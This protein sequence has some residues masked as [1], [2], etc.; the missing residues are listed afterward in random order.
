MRSATFY[1]KPSS[2]D[3][4]RPRT[5]EEAKTLLQGVVK[6]ELTDEEIKPI[7]DI[8]TRQLPESLYEIV[9]RI[10]VNES[11]YDDFAKNLLSDRGFIKGHKS[12]C[13]RKEG[14][15][16]NY[17]CLMIYNPTRE[18][19]LMVDSSGYNYARYVAK[20]PLVEIENTSGDLGQY[21][22]EWTTA[23]E[24]I[25]NKNKRQY[26]RGWGVTTLADISDN[27]N[28]DEYRQAH[29]L[30]LK[31]RDAFNAEAKHYDPETNSS[32]LGSI[33]DKKEREVMRSMWWEKLGGNKYGDYDKLTRIIEALH[34]GEKLATGTISFGS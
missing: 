27:A 26:F 9:Y 24:I 17:K 3:E 16:A 12:K 29:E 1:R 21:D 22:F 13:E 8:L 33:G 25:A 14:D 7:A 18:Y 34:C 23:D 15:I 30:W 19:A 20:V 4:M 32:R 10:E 31:L 5:A 28:D 2:V 11:V 6:K